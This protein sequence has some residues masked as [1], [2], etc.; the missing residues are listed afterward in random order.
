MP[1]LASHLTVAFGK[2]FSR[3]TS[4]G[5]PLAA[6]LPR[7]SGKNVQRDD[8]LI[9]TEGVEDTLNIIAPWIKSGAP[10]LLVWTIICALVGLFF[11]RCHLN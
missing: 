4:Q 11:P 2:H 8:E 1:S 7:R 10:V 5:K 9:L 6:P 3:M